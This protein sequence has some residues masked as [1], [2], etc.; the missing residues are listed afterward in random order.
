MNN[1]RPLKFRIYSFADKTFHYFD[2][3]EGYPS[4]IAFGVTYPEQYT[5]LNDKTGKEIYEGDIINIGMG[6]YQGSLG[7]VIFKNG[8][9]M[10]RSV[11]GAIY[12]DTYF[13]CVEGVITGNKHQNK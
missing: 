1:E 3:H 9:F 2:I 11:D 5:G 7:E 4:G 8:A 10:L 12:P 13:S 6:E